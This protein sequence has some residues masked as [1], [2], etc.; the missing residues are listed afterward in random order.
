LNGLFLAVPGLTPVALG[1]GTYRFDYQLSNKV[2]EY[3]RVE[4]Q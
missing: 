3:F 1:N 4:G 2:C